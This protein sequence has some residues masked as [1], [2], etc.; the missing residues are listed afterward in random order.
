MAPANAANCIC[1]PA[2]TNAI[3]VNKPLHKACNT[4]LA[5]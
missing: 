5:K 4:T 3:L 2:I 1:S